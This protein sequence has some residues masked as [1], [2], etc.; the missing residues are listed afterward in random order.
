[1][2][3]NLCLCCWWPACGP[4]EDWGPSVYQSIKTFDGQH[5]MDSQAV[6][7]TS[8]SLS[9]FWPWQCIQYGT[10]ENGR[11]AGHRKKW[12]RRGLTGTSALTNDG[13]VANPM[14]RAPKREPIN[15]S[16]AD[17]F[18]ALSSRTS[19][20]WIPQCIPLLL[21]DHSDNGG[22]SVEQAV[23]LQCKH[24]CWV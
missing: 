4:G 3:E 23:D 10:T 22:K 17:Q 15:A 21:I 16:Q 2:A 5:S 13:V 8:F 9:F 1:M 11:H 7:A 24:R 20:C 12:N 6:T 19:A 14:D 18:P